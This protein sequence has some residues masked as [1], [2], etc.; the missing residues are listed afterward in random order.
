MNITGDAHS[1]RLRADTPE[2]AVRLIQ[3]VGAFSSF[4]HIEEGE[5]IVGI[6]IS[7]EEFF[8]LVKR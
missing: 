4:K 2:D 6:E 3:F 7:T 1:I 8:N 5:H